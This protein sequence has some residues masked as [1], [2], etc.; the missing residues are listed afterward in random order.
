M[1]LTVGSLNSPEETR[2]VFRSRPVITRRFS[3]TQYCWPTMFLFS[4][5]RFSAI[6]SCLSASAP[7]LASWAACSV[8]YTPVLALTNRNSRKA[9]FLISR[10]MRSGSSTPGS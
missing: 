3:S 6:T 5:R 7:R 4:S 10:R 8:L 9:V 2:A 1:K